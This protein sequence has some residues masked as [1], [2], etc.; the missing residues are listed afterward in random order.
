MLKYKFQIKLHKCLQLKLL[1]LRLSFLKMKDLQVSKE[2]LWWIITMM[3]L[4]MKTLMI[5]SPII[6][7]HLCTHF[8]LEKQTNIINQIEIEEV[9]T[10]TNLEHQM[11]QW[12]V[13]ESSLWVN[14][15][16]QEIWTLN[17][18][19]SWLMDHRSFHLKKIFK[20]LHC[21]DRNHIQE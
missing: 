17:N 20:Q 12:K 15:Y 4:L 10:I 19:T 6:N 18:S 1:T 13:E 3:I 21:R 5:W 7:K 9:L 11:I 8:R 16:Q 2:D 14:L